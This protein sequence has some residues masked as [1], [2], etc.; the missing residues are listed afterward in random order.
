MKKDT[1]IKI[2]SGLLVL[3]IVV[4]AALAIAGVFNANNNTHPDSALADSDISVA[5]ISMFRGFDANTVLYVK[6]ADG[7]AITG[8]VDSIIRVKNNNGIV[9]MVVDT[10]ND[11]SGNP[12]YKP[13]DG[14]TEGMYYSVNLAS[15]YEFVNEQYAGLD[16]FE[17]I[18]ASRE[19]TEADTVVSDNV[20]FLAA[21]QYTVT[22]IAGTEYYTLQAEG[23]IDDA[24]S[25]PV[26]VFANGIDSASYRLVQDSQ[27]VKSATGY[28]ATVE[29]ADID[30]VYDALYISKNYSVSG[31]DLQFDLDATEASIRSCD[32]YLA[33][34]DYLYGESL[35][36]EKTQNKWV[37]VKIDPGFEAGSPSKVTLKVT[38][39]FKG[40]TK[41]ANGERDEDS[42]ITIL[43]NN[44]FTP[45]FDVHIQKEEG[46]KGFD[47]NLDLDVDTT[48]SVTFTISKSGY[49][50][51][52]GKDES[53]E[54]IANKVAELVR[55]VSADKLGNSDNSAKPYTFAKWIIPI[56]TLPIC[57][58]DNLGIELKASFSGKVGVTASNKFHTSVGVVY[59][60]GD[61][62]GYGN[63]DDNFHFGGITLAGSAG[64]RVGLI[65]EIGIS[66]YGTISVD[67]GL[68]VGVYADIA[69]RLE[70]DGDDL[71]KLFTRAGDFNIIPAYYFETGVYLDLTAAGKVFGFTLKQFTLLSK[72][73]P[74]FTAG[75][76]YL[77]VEGV[78]NPFV[79]ETIYMESS[80]YYLQNWEVNA[81]DIQNITADSTK[82]SLAYTEFDYELGEGL[83]M[84]GNKL[85]ATKA[86]E[87]TSWVKVTSKVNKKLSKTVTIIKNPEMPTA[88]VKEKVYDTNEPEDVYYDVMLNGS[89]LIG[90]S[91]NGEAIAYTYGDGNLVLSVDS[92]AAALAKK[93]IA[94]GANAVSVESSKGYLGL[95]LRVVS[96]ADVAVDTAKKVYDKAAAGALTWSM[97]LQGNDIAEVREGDTVVDSK[98]YSYRDGASFVMSAAYWDAKANGD[99]TETVA[100]VGSDITYDLTVSV[101]DSRSAYLLTS[102]YS[103]VYGSNEDLA[104]AVELFDNDIQSITFDGYP[105]KSDGAVIP[106]DYFEDKAI[107][108]YNGSI[109]GLAFSVVITKANNALVIPK[110]TATYYKSSNEAVVFD[111]K[112]MPSTELYIASCDGFSQNAD[113]VS[114]SAAFLSKWSGDVWSD[115]IRGAD[116]AV[117]LTIN[118]VNDVLP[119][120]AETEFTISGDEVKSIDWNLQGY[121]IKDLYVSGLP[122]EAYTVAK[123]GLKVSGAA[124]DYGTIQATV[125]TP[126][127]AMSFCIKHNGTPSIAS[128][129]ALNKTSGDEVT[130][131]L[132]VAHLT[133]DYVEVVET[134]ILP[135]QYRYTNGVLTLS[136]DFVYNLAAGNY[137]L[138]VY[139][140]EGEPLTTTLTI[141]GEMQAVDTVG[142]G[143]STH[144]FLI[145]TAD[146]LA[147]VY[148][149]VN[150]QGKS[151]SCYKLMADIDM[152]GYSMEPIGTEEHPYNGVFDGNGYTISN[153]N[154]TK[155]VK[156]GKDGYAIGM[157]GFVGASGVVMD[158]RLLQANVKFA[159]SGSVSAG[160]IAGRNEGTIKSIYIN[161]SSISAE[162]KSWLDIKNA[163]FDLGAV[164]GYNNGGAIRNVDVTADISGKVKGLNVAG[165]QIFGRKSLINVGA[166]VGYF[167][168]AD[169][170]SSKLV[171]SIK[172]TA[173]ISTSVDN[174]NPV[175]QN[176]WYGYTDLS[177]DA[178]VNCVKRC[179][180]SIA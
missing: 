69:G 29:A 73:F 90:V 65:N 101:Q 124:L 140:S 49:S 95:V 66:A 13:Q 8:S 93:K 51:G 32:W 2:V 158:V 43:I 111:V 47:A 132:D 34:V 84:D 58:E 123:D 86:G 98:Y 30:D 89:K 173:N 171:S 102:E 46:K 118:I 172:V 40:I 129:Y 85:I 75:H 21:G 20:V 16:S 50:Y 4:V 71:I 60:D 106:A 78:D 37:N 138:K 156:V 135:I 83:R 74:L 147:G 149:Y 19:S 9:K 79:D 136:N 134:L 94:Y 160:L 54:A 70:L 163:Y 130:Y 80:Y 77:P 177:E 59:A 121:D 139:L 141:Q 168:T 87:F 145:Y 5:E 61:L 148:A 155:T 170:E 91:V 162:S 159:Q 127:N 68:H 48:A 42:V 167:T 92:I 99:Y 57:I 17:C 81:L 154:I 64:A 7:S 53:M 12:G 38:I 143:D 113:S 107:G 63:V 153:L 39:T 179:K 105:V 96:S 27:V 166:V 6:A 72:Q 131:A 62:K 88:S 10:N 175:N 117:T 144:P 174:K 120:L 108:T 14:W 150:K 142:Q 164:V 18:V 15:G 104:L 3:A 44:V 97:A 56:G 11:A 28:T 26:F 25:A 115:T 55:K 119:T 35:S 116:N 137:T 103:Y 52:E 100:L 128:G 109:N 110:Q 76:K 126:V 36:D 33:A 157:F 180:V 23:S 82:R 24:I 41:K 152:S 31:A 178:I 67:L 169:K 22:P 112:K 122:T 133:F 45:V 165:I 176:G 1:A 151:A 146:Q 125:Y 114:I 161:G